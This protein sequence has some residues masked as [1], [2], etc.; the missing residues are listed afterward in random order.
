[1]GQQ[2]RA[3]IFPVPFLVAFQLRSMSFHPLNFETPQ[4]LPQ[5]RTVPISEDSPNDS[6]PFA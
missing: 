2:F 4:D 5:D 6:W 1:M 3:A